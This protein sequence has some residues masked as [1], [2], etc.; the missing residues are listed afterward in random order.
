[1][2]ERNC[3]PGA[4]QI[5]G[6]TRDR[7]G[8]FARCHFSDVNLSSVLFTRRLDDPKLIELQ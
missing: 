5:K 7:T 4:K 1:Y 8:N 2:P 6:L 3:S